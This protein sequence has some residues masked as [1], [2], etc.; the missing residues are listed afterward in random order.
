MTENPD[1]WRR[2]RARAAALGSD[3]CTGVPDWHRDCCLEHDVHERT[4]MDIHGQAISPAESDARFHECLRQ[5]SP[6][7][8]WSPL[9]WAYW[10]GV[11]LWR[12]YVQDRNHQ[13]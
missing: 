11:R 5:R 8:W 7:S 12:R 6:F 10:G 4:G 3:G 9:A 13:A 1:Y 2:V